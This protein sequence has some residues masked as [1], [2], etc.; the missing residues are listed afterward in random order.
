[1]QVVETHLAGVLIVEP[2][3]FTDER[4][5]FFESF[6]QSK[7]EQATGV[8]RDWVQD[9]H[10]RSTGGVL[11]GLHFQNPNPQGKLVRC[12]AGSVWDVAVDLRTSSPAFGQWVGIEL[13]SV[14]HRQLW[15][16]E[17]FAH[18]YLTLSES[19]EILYKTT[20]YYDPQHDRSLRWDDPK[21]NIKWPLECDPVLSLKDR[22]APLLDQIDPFV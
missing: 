3:V 7:F 1:M 18:G 19:A 17:G 8:V 5:F 15:I 16:P 4:G 6:N 2:T 13:S 20:E 12:I 14:N 22:D 21:L 9:N 11:R 10:S